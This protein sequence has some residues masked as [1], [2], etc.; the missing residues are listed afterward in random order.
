MLSLA[1]T[2][3]YY[4]PHRVMN[5]ISSEL[6]TFVFYNILKIIIFDLGSLLLPRLF[7]GCSERGLLF[8]VVH[9]LLMTVAS[10]VEKHGL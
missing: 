3:G 8:I 6:L 1:P 7:S 4:H 5:L 10:L 9:R 2:R